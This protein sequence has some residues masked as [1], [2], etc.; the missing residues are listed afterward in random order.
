[1]PADRQGVDRIDVELVL[2]LRHQSHIDAEPQC[3]VKFLRGHE[4]RKH[5]GPS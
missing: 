4:D 3:A 1:M 5:G 2:F